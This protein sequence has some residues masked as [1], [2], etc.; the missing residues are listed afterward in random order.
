[1]EKYSFWQP[2]YQNI[3]MFYTG[4]AIIFAFAALMRFGTLA[5]RWVAAEGGPFEK[6]RRVL[7]STYQKALAKYD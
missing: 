5:N 3:T 6:S 7:R 4:L 1:M 2:I